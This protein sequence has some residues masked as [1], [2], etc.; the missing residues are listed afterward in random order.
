MNS[1][2]KLICLLIFL[3]NGILEIQCQSIY[4]DELSKKTSEINAL[5]DVN[6]DSALAYSLRTINFYN[7]FKDTLSLSKLYMVTGHCYFDLG[8][9]DSA[10]SYYHLALKEDERFNVEISPGIWISL[11]TLYYQI[12]AFQLSSDYAKRII[13]IDADS[14]KEN[15]TYPYRSTALSLLGLNYSDLMEHDSALYYYRIALAELYNDNGTLAEN[16]DSLSL[17]YLWTNIGQAYS[18]KFEYDSAIYYYGIAFDHYNRNSSWDNIAFI[19]EKITTLYLELNQLDSAYKYVEISRTAASKKSRIE[20][21]KDILRV[22]I[23]YFSKA[24][25]FDS[26]DTYLDRY[27]LMSDSVIS[28]KVSQNIQ[29]METKYRVKEKT[30]ELKIEKEKRERLKA[31]NKVVIII[32][33]VLVLFAFIVILN[34]RQ[35]NK[36][37][38][39]ELEIKDNKMDELM[40]NQ[41]SKAL[42]AMLNG[43]EKERERI[44][45]DLHDR[46]GGTLAALKLSLRKPG[47]KVDPDDLKIVDEAVIEVRNISHNLSSGLL[48]KYGLNEAIRQLFNSIGKSGGLKFNL[49]LHPEIAVLG[50]SI[51]IELYRI[52]QE[53]MANTIKHAKASEVS[54]QTNFDGEV[55]NLIFEDNGVGFDLQKIKGG[56]GMENI[57][58]RVKRIKGTFHIDTSPGRGSI[59]IIE[60]N[61]KV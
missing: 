27:I 34:Y 7:K 50:Q 39:M 6:N 35:R 61:K 17:T 18:Y 59:F 37:T 51:G 10:S 46:L 20:T 24:K 25:E 16:V 30:A 54:L 56:I 26:L 60:L 38:A 40:A 21:E 1:V 45:Q 57:K 22:Q 53:L 4:S 14:L 47:N 9:Y 2:L 42:S 31:E 3:V 55:F 15:F 49:Y 8:N 23:E 41:E 48:D 33:V 36:I 32:S 13:S 43:Q 58:K 29:D 52:V 19:G 11:S 5:L 44:A 28:E 12:N